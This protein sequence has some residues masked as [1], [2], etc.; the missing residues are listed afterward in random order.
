MI[1][2]G[3]RKRTVPAKKSKQLPMKSKVALWR[4]VYIIIIIP[5]N[6]PISIFQAKIFDLWLKELLKSEPTHVDF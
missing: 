6:I 1:R 2:T 5:W 3:I 4:K